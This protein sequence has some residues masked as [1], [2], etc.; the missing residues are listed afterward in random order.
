LVVFLGEN[1]WI[2]LM[3]NLQESPIFN[4]EIHGFLQIFP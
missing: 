3:E 4:G 1:Q 2:G